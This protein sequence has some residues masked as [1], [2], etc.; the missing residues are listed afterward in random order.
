MMG[1]ACD[2]RNTVP[3]PVL[4]PLL[5]GSIDELLAGM[6][7]KPRELLSN[8]SVGV[9]TA[10]LNGLTNQP[11]VFIAGGGPDDFKSSPI[12]FTALRMANDRGIERPWLLPIL[13]GFDRQ[14]D[15]DCV[16][17]IERPNVNSTPKRG[18]VVLSI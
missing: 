13:E 17:H 14:V 18:L 12:I 3:V 5:R 2:G 11:D 4:L 15:C 9:H 7:R 16:S 6:S 10:I 1:W 8:G